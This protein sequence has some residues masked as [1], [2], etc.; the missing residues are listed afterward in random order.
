MKWLVVLVVVLVLVAIVMMP[1]R[2][3]ANARPAAARTQPE[4]EQA[5]RRLVHA[6]GPRPVGVIRAHAEHG[7]V[8][9]RGAVEVG[10]QARRVVDFASPDFRAAHDGETGLIDLLEELR[11][12][13]I[14]SAPGPW[15]YVI[16]SARPDD[17][18]E[19]EY[20][21]E[22][23]PLASI[24]DLKLEQY[25]HV[26]AH[27][28]RQRFDAA[29]VAE[30]SDFEVN[31]GIA[32]H[33]ADRIDAGSPVSPVLL[34]LFATIDWEGDVNNGGMD[35]YF[36]RRHSDYSGAPRREYYPL[37]HAGLLRIGADAAAALFAESI[38]LYAHFHPEVEQ[39]R[40]AMGIPAVARQETSDI[41]GRYYRFQADLDRLRAAHVRAHP[42]VLEVAVPGKP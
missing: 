11:T 5:I 27:V 9:F 12:A 2:A 26:P 19:F 30:L 25:D 34:E 8:G 16:I 17:A 18:I 40:V 7:A 41:G 14:A 21:L 22:R 35:Q 28:F 10:D 33:V 39:A 20:F 13:S 36:A 31:A 37:V 3:R 32:A 29:L 24:A 15:Y 23:T 38:A 42:E 4:V 1:S 6:Q